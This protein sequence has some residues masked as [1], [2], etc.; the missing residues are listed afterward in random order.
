M[1]LIDLPPQEFCASPDIGR[2]FVAGRDGQFRMFHFPHC[3]VDMQTLFPVASAGRV[4]TA[5]FALYEAQKYAQ[6]FTAEFAAELQRHPRVDLEHVFVLGGS[7]N[8]WHFL[9]DH[10]ATIALLPAF[11]ESGI[12]MPIV[13]ANETLNP[14]YV[15]LLEAGCDALRIPR[16]QA[17]A[18]AQRVMRFRDAYVPCRSPQGP[19]FD[20]LRDLGRS[21]QAED[22]TDAPERIFIRRGNVAYRRIAN[23]VE[24]ERAL[25]RRFGFVGVNTGEMSPFDQVRLMRN[26]RIVVGGHGAALANL[27][28]GVKLEQVVELYCG[29]TQPFFKA[30]CNH[31]GT[32]HS[33][34]EGV[35]VGEGSIEWDPGRPDNRD[36]SVDAERLIEAIGDD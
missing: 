26:A 6:Y 18:S 21:L 27:L 3:L 14:G 13:V 36:F 32:A 34:F 16:P 29:A 5:M 28:F 10:L 24:V 7:P 4:C 8:Y 1:H 15:R 20:F 25:A 17:V 35:A 30:V 12:A 23:E 22:G 2:H 19:R 31:W 9:V 33:F 11:A